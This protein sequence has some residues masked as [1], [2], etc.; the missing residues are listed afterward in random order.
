[1]VPRP[2]ELGASGKHGASTCTQADPLKSWARIV[3]CGDAPMTWLDNRAAIKILDQAHR[4]TAARPPADGSKSHVPRIVT[5]GGD[6][7]TTLSALRGTYDNWGRVSVVHFDSHIDTW[8][9][10]VLGKNLI[11]ALP[12][13]PSIS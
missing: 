7:T 11:K 3:D 4:L 6:H 2:S 10:K 12:L 9:P 8:D 1:M 5:L 13:T